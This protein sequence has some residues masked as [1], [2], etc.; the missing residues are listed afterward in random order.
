[1]TQKQKWIT[2]RNKE[3]YHCYLCGVS[4]AA[5][6]EYYNLHYGTIKYAIESMGDKK[7]VDKNFHQKIIQMYIEGLSV[8]EI[9]DS[10]SIPH[11]LVKT[12]INTTIKSNRKRFEAISKKNKEIS[13]QRESGRTCIDIAREYGVSKQWVSSTHRIYKRQKQIAFLPLVS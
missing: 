7:P 11:K 12:I 8:Q 10:F 4:F 3:I 9:G 1:M 2:K 5:L 13:E 6:S